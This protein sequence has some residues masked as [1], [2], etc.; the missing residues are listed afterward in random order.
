MPTLRFAQ[1]IEIEV[2]VQR[3]DTVQLTAYLNVPS[4]L[5]AAGRVSLGSVTLSPRNLSQTL[6]L[7]AMEL[8]TGY[9]ASVAIE[10]DPA[11]T[12]LRLQASAQ[13]EV[14]GQDIGGSPWSARRRAGRFRGP[15]P[16]Y[17]LWAPHRSPMSWS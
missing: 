10:I 5:P 14:A 3:F 6:R 15:K 4:D 8:G 11:K 13:V 17:G 16:R 9:L 1:I 7:D 12:L 2:E